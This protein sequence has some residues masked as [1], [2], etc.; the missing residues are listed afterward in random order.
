VQAAWTRVAAADRSL[1]AAI[2]ERY[3]RLSL[4]AKAG[5][6]ASLEG[7]LASIAANLAAPLLDGGKRAAEVDRARAAE[8]QSVLEYQRA[9]VDAAVEVEDALAREAGQTAYLASLDRQVALADSTVASARTLYTA[10]L[11]DHLR[12]L[13]AE[14]S[15]QSVAR[16][17]L[18]ATE[19]LL[20]IRI[21]LYR[22]IAGGFTL[23]PPAGPA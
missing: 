1:A 16:E 10:G 7:W 5:T 14:R 6:A 21:G 3:P 19:E 15:Q 20:E 13:D 8:A 18:A 9:V 23:A 11:T 12:V 4:S 17:R 22:A 2:S